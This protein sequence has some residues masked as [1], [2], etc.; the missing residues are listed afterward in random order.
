MKS[1][2]YVS[3]AIREFTADELAALL[4]SCRERNGRVGITGMLLYRGGN[5]M[6]LLEG[7]DVVVDTVYAKIER[8]PRHH[9]CSV[10]ANYTMEQRM[11]PEWTMGFHEVGHPPMQGVEGYNELMRRSWTAHELFRDPSISQRLLLSFRRNMR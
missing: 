4:S 1:L 10:L 6:Q 2:I 7:D 8:D 3:S 9:Q 5:F 11:F